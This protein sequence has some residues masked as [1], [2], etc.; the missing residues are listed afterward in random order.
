M[1]DRVL[2]IK[3]I[4][5]ASTFFDGLELAFDEVML[6]VMI[7]M[8]EKVTGEAQAKAPS[9][10]GLFR[11]SI[12]P[13]PEKLAPMKVQGLVVST[14]P[15]AAIIEGVNED[16]EEVEFGRRPNTAFPNIGELEQWVERTI[17]IEAI[18]ARYLEE[19]DIKETS[20]SNDEL[21]RQATL[22]VGRK[23]VH[24]GI[25]PK[26]P[27]GEAFRQNTQLINREIDSAIDEI[28]QVD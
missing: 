4:D 16:G 24:D 12:Q 22:S 28:F 6:P 5:E 26:R 19:H 3:I 18:H 20:L 9:Y 2:E 13:I 8:T 23:I 14:S 15:Y 21:L 25:R 17:G 11:S 27:I 7:A 1:S 10:N